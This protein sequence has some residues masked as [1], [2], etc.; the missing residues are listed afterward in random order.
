MAETENGSAKETRLDEAELAHLH[1]DGADYRTRLT[2]KYT[3]R[4]RYERRDARL[5]RA[6]IPGEVR[7]ILVA[8]GQRVRRGEGLLILEAMKMQNEVTA[9]VD[10][11]VRRVAVDS[12]QKVAKGELLVELE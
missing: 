8:P 11:V 1:V 5:V 2:R 12:L 3:L 7:R 6:F 10:G 9:T 4:P